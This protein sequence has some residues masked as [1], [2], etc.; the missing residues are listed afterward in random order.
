MLLTGS[1]LFE[2]LYH[3][4]SPRPISRPT[5]VPCE[6][7]PVSQA[8]RAVK[9][10][11]N[12]VAQPDQHGNASLSAAAPLQPPRSVSRALSKPVAYVGPCRTL[13]D[14]T[15]TVT[16]MTIARLEESDRDYCLIVINQS[17]SPAQAT[18]ALRDELHRRR[19]RRG[20]VFRRVHS[21]QSEPDLRTPAG[22]SRAL[23]APTGIRSVQ[24]RRSIS[25]L[26]SQQT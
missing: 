21:T 9:S 12:T 19:E 16:F 22:Q 23:T 17:D 25:R 5:P 2:V 18:A 4:T 11:T 6:E 1:R 15:G 8:F 13:A 14:E 7:S 10:W 26:R 20:E 3:L 24:L